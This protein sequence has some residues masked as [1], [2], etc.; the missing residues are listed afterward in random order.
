MVMVFMVV[1]GN[2]IGKRHDLGRSYFVTEF[3]NIKLNLLRKTFMNRL[4]SL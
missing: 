2:V 3:V 4:I 1:G